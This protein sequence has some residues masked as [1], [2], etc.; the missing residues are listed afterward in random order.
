MYKRVPPLTILGHNGPTTMPVCN[1]VVPC[2]SAWSYSIVLDSE[3]QYC[4][5]WKVSNSN[6][7][8]Q[9]SFSI[10]SESIFLIEIVKHYT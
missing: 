3:E 8:M 4:S 2:R 7:I 9:A 10:A 1:C 6:V 5:G